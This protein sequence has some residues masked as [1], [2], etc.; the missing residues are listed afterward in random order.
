[1]TDCGNSKGKD[2]LGLTRKI[3]PSTGQAP[4]EGDMIFT[5]A[6]ALGEVSRAID[7]HTNRRPYELG[8]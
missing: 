5:R 2:R 6:E 1:M 7:W 8:T 4:G 3:V